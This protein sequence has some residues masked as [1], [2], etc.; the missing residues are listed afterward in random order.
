[1]RYAT[2]GTVTAGTLLTTDLLATFADELEFHINRNAEHFNANDTARAERD[3]LVALIGEAREYEGDGEDAG[4]IMDDLDTELNV[5]APP[6]C[7]FGALEG[8]GADIGYWPAL[9]AIRELPRIKDAD[10]DAAR[11]L[12]EDCA[13]VNDHGNVTVFGGDGTVLLDIV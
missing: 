11:A 6:Y 8:D 2:I 10:A 5:F 13:F 7:Y 12:G 1:M 3:R 9:D 4:E